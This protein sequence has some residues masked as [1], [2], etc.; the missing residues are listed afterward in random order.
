V[1]NTEKYTTIRCLNS[2]NV[3]NKITTNTNDNF[4]PTEGAKPS[5]MLAV[6]PSTL[7]FIKWIDHQF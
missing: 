4:K 7:D 3:E 2:T 1:I 5:M 6:E